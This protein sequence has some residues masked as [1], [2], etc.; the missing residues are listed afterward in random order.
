MLQL[1]FLLTGTP[2]KIY[3]WVVTAG[4]QLTH[5]IS[6]PHFTL[7]DALVIARMSSLFTCWFVFR[8]AY[9]HFFLDIR[10]LHNSDDLQL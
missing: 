3:A 9:I 2:F 1:S 8:N 7:F 5:T 6:I 4:I 10:R